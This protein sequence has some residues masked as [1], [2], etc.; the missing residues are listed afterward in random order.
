MIIW[1]KSAAAGLR[2]DLVDLV[3]LQGRP[4]GL[5][6][7][8]VSRAES[9][10]PTPTQ[11]GNIIDPAQSF[12]LLCATIPLFLV[13]ALMM[14]LALR[15]RIFADRGLASARPDQRHMLY[16]FFHISSL[17]R[18]GISLLRNSLR[19]SPYVNY[20]LSRSLPGEGRG[21]SFSGSV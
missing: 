12:Y 21:G 17:P 6:D 5:S 20:S 19:A 10:E 1:S 18:P 7:L 4:S 16:Y 9:C 8:S 2:V 11:T 13:E 14:P 15:L 3:G